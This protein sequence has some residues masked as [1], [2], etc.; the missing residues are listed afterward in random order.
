[1]ITKEQVQELSKKLSID[2][3]SVFREYLQIVFL[4]AL[5]SQKL[6]QEVFFK[7]GTAIRLLLNSFRF[8]EDLDFTTTLT[9]LEIEAVLDKVLQELRLIVPNITIKQLK[10]IQKSYTGSLRC[11]SDDYKY[12]VNIHL[13]FSYREK[14]L[15]EKESILETL[16]PVS[17]YPI[18]IHMD[19]NEILAEKIRALLTRAKG[20]DLF[21]MWYLMSKDIQIDLKLINK[22]MELHNKKITMDDVIKKIE[23]FSDEKLKEDLNKYLPSTHRKITNELKEM[24]LKKFSSL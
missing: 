10:T 22:K 9:H 16:F 11:E 7:G 21:D 15:T 4:S 12:P 18:I 20:R 14:P 8:S 13:D 6:S 24:V 5:Y 3:Y 1:M 23:S 2:W 19:W 17:P